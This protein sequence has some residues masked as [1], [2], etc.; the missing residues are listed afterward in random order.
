MKKLITAILMYVVLPCLSMAQTVKNF[1]S[2]AIISPYRIQ[3][4][5]QK[6][7]M[8]LFPTAVKSVDR[9]S[10]YVLAEKVKDAENVIKL[11]AD[12]QG[13]PE[14]NLSVIT[15]DGKLYSFIVTTTTDL[16]TQAIDLHQQEL[17]ERS[18]VR[19]SGESLNETQVRD[20]SARAT[21]VKPFMNVKDKNDQMKMKL[22]GI[23]LAND[24]MF[25][26]LRVNN[27]SH[28][29][30]TV[31]FIRFYIRDR[32]KVKRM[33]VQEQEITPLACYPGDT[34]TVNGNS[35]RT[36]VMAFKKFTIADNKN[37]AVELYEKNGDRH[38]AM[39][40]DG[41]EI[42]KARPVTR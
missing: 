37:L 24:V 12:H 25:Y 20:I 41:K 16:P 4:S 11:K 27:K 35:H 30:Y 39:T 14:S 8:I 33:A 7:L 13:I 34:L 28:I 32:K 5:D 29:N 1:D 26:R 36:I 40:L 6:T 42:L 9:G 2:S 31:D 21:L 23:Y 17:R 22:E 18:A 15:A 3:I 10:R 19:F 38:L